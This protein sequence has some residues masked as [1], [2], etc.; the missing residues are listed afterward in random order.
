[1]SQGW[2]ESN[3]AAMM[4]FVGTAVVAR[5]G[6][7]T[8]MTT[9]PSRENELPGSRRG[10]CLGC[11][12]RVVTARDAHVL[13]GGKRDGSMLAMF[14]AAPLLMLATDPDRLFEPGLELLGMAHRSCADLARQRLEAPRSTCRTSCHSSSP[15]RRSGTC[16]R[17]TCHLRQADARSAATPRSPMSPSG[18]S[19]SPASSAAA[20]ASSSPR[21]TD[22][23]CGVILV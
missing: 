3:P 14:D 13:F 11:D 12:A 18:L 1:M 9:G 7:N 10:L 22:H 21:H 2:G 8:G 15:M 19:G 17:C 20:T 5:P 6:N 16:R 4:R 23:G